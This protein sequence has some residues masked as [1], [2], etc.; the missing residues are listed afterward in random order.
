MNQATLAKAKD[1]LPALALLVLAWQLHLLIYAILL[2]APVL[3]CE[4]FLPGLDR[5]KAIGL[6]LFFCFL[7]YFGNV[8]T[9]LTLAPVG[10]LGFSRALSETLSDLIKYPYLATMA[11]RYSIYRMRLL[12]VLLAETGLALLFINSPTGRGLGLHRIF[13]VP[14]GFKIAQST[15]MGSANWATEKE[16]RNYFT[17]EGPGL[18]VGMNDKKELYILPLTNNKFEY[19]RNQNIV[20]F[21]TTGSGK[22]GSFVKPNILQ[23]DGSYFITDPKQELYNELAPY[24]RKHGYK[25]YRF[26]LVDMLASER[27]NPLV[28]KD[29]TC[30]LSIQDAVLISSSIIKNSKDPTEKTND[31]FWDKAEQ[32]LL[33]ALILYASKYFTEPKTFS[34]ILKFATGRT[35]AALDYDFGKLPP[36]DPARAAYNIYAHATEAVRGSVIISVGTRLQLFQD[37]KLA[38]LTSASDF[39]L[40]EPGLEKT[41]IFVVISDA[42]DTYNSISALFFSQAFQELYK[43]A[44]KHNGSLPMFTRFIMDEFCN[45]GFIPAYT[46]KLSTM[47]SRGI[48]SQM[49]IQSW[50]QLN[51]RY[52]FGMADEI[53]G[54]CDIRLMLGA[55]DSVTAKYFVDLIGKTTVE[56]EMHSHS[57]R[58]MLDAGIRGERTSARELITADEILRLDNRKAL[59]IVRGGNPA[60][61]NKAFYKDHPGAKELDILPDAELKL[62][63]TPKIAPEDELVSEIE[64]NRKSDN[65]K[66]EIK[67]AE[68]L[69]LNNDV[70]QP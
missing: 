17:R 2:I 31:P 65:P 58:V 8:I 38:H 23:A 15:A 69:D 55:N 19:Q 32:A 13:E 56:Q 20:V 54:N 7:W 12:S 22:T 16:L 5:R 44:A 42:D 59:L 29:G 66:T 57:D 26:N 11:L 34:N 49:I 47:R 14:G 36:T 1:Y 4:R 35:P 45:I 25:V 18:I 52:P 3:L 51:N 62:T 68:P 63:R 9:F 21:G 24:L 48:S 43:L 53:I 67:Q 39:D 6:G 61:V 70:F 37:D 60:I 30:D 41:A 33:T 27:W 50:G 28:K 64:Q 46:V 40:T 10:K